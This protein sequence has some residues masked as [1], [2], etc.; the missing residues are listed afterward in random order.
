M[1]YLKYFFLFS[2]IFVSFYGTDKVLVYLDNKKPLM[3]EIMSVQDN[4]LTEPVNGVIKDNTIIPGISGRSVNLKAS[5]VKM[6]DFGDFNENFLV[7]DEIKP[8]ISLNKNLDKIIIRGNSKKRM[9]SLV[10]EDNKDILRYL[11]SIDVKYDVLANKD[12]SF[13]DNL[14]YLNGYQ[15]KDDFNDLES[16]LKNKKKSTKICLL[17][18]NNYDLCLKKKYYLVFSSL[19]SDNKINDILS[20]IS[21]GE[22]ILIKKSTSLSNMK[23]IISEINRQDLKIVFLSELI[24]ES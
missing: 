5:L 22:I 17:D 2:F 9:V 6:E 16:I 8:D 23:L 21:S 18:V 20:N 11:D 15:N 14:E 1:K 3:K 7:Y 24:S 13:S 4:Y 10:L 12:S 19:S